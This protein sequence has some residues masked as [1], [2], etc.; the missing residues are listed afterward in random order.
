MSA[1][2]EPATAVRTLQL[3]IG[4]KWV[5]SSATATFDVHNPAK[6][7]LLARTPMG[8]AGDVDRAVQAAAKA[9]PAWRATPPVNRVRH[10]FKMKELFE[11]SFEDLA[12][13]CTIEHGKTLDESRSSIR[14][15]IDNIDMAIGIPNTM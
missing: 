10:L 5:D 8:G 3:Y 14:R 4:G 12:R 11:K 7:E 13:T 2:R 1:T 15:A 6:H 9:Y